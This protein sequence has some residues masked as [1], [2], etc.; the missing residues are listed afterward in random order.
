MVNRTTPTFMMIPNINAPS[1]GF[2][3]ENPPRPPSS[4]SGEGSSVGRRP[5]PRRTLATR[6]MPDLRASLSRRS[7]SREDHVARRKK[8]E[9][10][11]E[12]FAEYKSKAVY[13]VDSSTLC[14]VG[15]S[16]DQQ[17]KVGPCGSRGRCKS[18]KLW[19]DNPRQV[20]VTYNGKSV[21]C[22]I[23]RE[24][25]CKTK[26]VVYCLTCPICSI[27]Y[28]GETQQALATRISAHRR[29]IEQ[30]KENTHLVNHF[31][32]AHGIMVMPVLRILETMNENSDTAS[33]REAE[34]KWTLVLNTAHPW[35][36]NSN[37]KGF[38][39]ISQDTDPAE[40]RSCPW[41]QCRYERIIPRGYRERKH[42]K[43]SSARI[44]DEDSAKTA[45]ER[46]ESKDTL[47]DRFIMLSMMKSAE[48]RRLMETSFNYEN[49]GFACYQQIVSF[50]LAHHGTN[51]R[52][53]QQAKY[54]PFSYVNRHN[55]VL[56][57]E[58]ILRSRNI[59]PDNI[60]KDLIPE[61][62]FTKSFTETT[63]SRLLNYSRFLRSLDDG[64]LVDMMQS[65]CK[66]VE[67][68]L[69]RYVDSSQGHICTGD[70]EIIEDRA[71]RELVEKGAKFRQ[72]MDDSPSTAK[73]TCLE[74]MQLF[75]NRLIAPLGQNVAKELYTAVVNECEKLEA[76]CIRHQRRPLRQVQ[77]VR[78]TQ[79]GTKDLQDAF[80]I[81][82]VDKAANNFAFTCPKH[83]VNIMC[84]ELGVTISGN[85]VHAAGNLVYYETQMTEIEIIKEH[86]RMNVRY[87]GERLDPA[88]EVIPLL[89]A[90]P[91]FHKNPMK[92]RFIAGAKRASTKELSVLL[93]RV[94]YH[95]KEHWCRY[96]RSVEE[97]TN[98]RTY[99]PVSDSGQVITM[100]RRRRMPDNNRIVVADFSTL[101]TSFEHDVIIRHA[102]ALITLL[103]EHSRHKYVSLGR[104]GYYH[105][106]ETRNGVKLTKEDVI[107]L[108]HYLVKNSY[109]KFAG[110]TFHQK[111]GIPMGAN[112]SPVLADMCLSHMEYVYLKSHPDQARR[113]GL[114]VRY[115]D[116]ILSVGTEALREL[117]KEIYPSSL[118][119]TF[120]DTSDGTAHYLDLLIDRNKRSINLFDKRNDFKFSVIRF[121]DSGSNVP[122]SMSLNVLYSQTIRV[123]RI[124]TEPIEFE[125]N[126]RELSDVMKRKGFA[127]IEIS[128]T[129][130]KVRQRY[131]VLL[132]KH[133][134]RHKHDIQRLIR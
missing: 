46:Y 21:E 129:L 65:N 89:W 53:K 126:M 95:L 61:V 74:S 60:D 6:G 36:L 108:T 24:A 18:C 16:G 56:N 22:K 25:N 1:I 118:P 119:L 54:I 117:A 14:V 111:S 124:C 125:S 72:T 134:I 91:K 3:G 45:L 33:R 39:T 107:E 26:N 69:T 58:R 83:Y 114:T 96:N 50:Q 62:I 11:P 17:L 51:A 31:T 97:R 20:R 2:R 103:F 9:R 32:K 76:R 77:S 63:G 12:T 38:G 120:D 5:L 104:K 13:R 7:G 80:V 93:A 123:A 71:T 27:N 44:T 109:V 101:Y 34:A 115:I 40:R 132:L 8:R 133:G 73:K 42:K 49:S 87:L 127:S 67:D 64:K 99:W 57:P 29:N 41:F 110:R 90:A 94:L 68:R 79:R 106:S 81:T 112:Y 105:S 52:T 78:A 88:N 43:D 4:I 82:P 92:F 85:A 131:P 116:D 10:L 98:Y 48:V 47:R 130:S 84:R 100:L 75:I 121:T 19:D 35:G 28:V 102:V 55:N 59:M 113:L 122:R 23:T 70:T 15:K 128:R 86:N 37:V 66:C 30:N